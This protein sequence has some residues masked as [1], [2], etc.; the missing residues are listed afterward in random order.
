MMFVSIW[1]HAFILHISD[2]LEVPSIQ[3]SVTLYVCR[4]SGYLVCV[5]ALIEAD[6][7]DDGVGVSLIVH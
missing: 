2:R 7:Q 1:F 3:V 6:R 4:E 5:F